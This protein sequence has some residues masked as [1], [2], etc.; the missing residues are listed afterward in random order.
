MIR[1]NLLKT[2]EKKKSHGL[3]K[4]VITGGII[5]AGA[6]VF[7]LGVIVSWKLVAN[8]RK[9]QSYV[10]VEAPRPKPQLDGRVVE[11]VVREVQNENAMTPRMLSLPYREQRFQEKVNYEIHFGRN[12]CAFLEKVVPEGIRFKKFEASDFNTLYGSG[13]SDSRENIKL[14]F[15]SYRDQDATILPKPHTTIVKS[16]GGYQFVI[17]AT[18][19]FGLDLEA[20]FIDL[21]LDHLA[22][23]A[24]LQQQLQKLKD[25][26]A[27][28]GVLIITG[29]K[30]LPVEK[31]GDSQR[32]RYE[33]SGTS[34]YEK[35]VSFINGA[36]EARIPCAFEKFSVVAL[37][38]DKVKVDAQVLFT[39]IR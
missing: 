13:L 10:A 39:T 1:I 14:L 27:E 4:G 19:E 35:F 8:L 29:P 30:A 9:P 33:F 21:G 2:V 37:S 15:L 23:A 20:P 38:D 24:E 12:V 16:D 7:A 22:K 6:A 18:K 34:S 31:L 28:K 3:P 5:V 26:A 17:S 36:F 32:F 11:E 25:V